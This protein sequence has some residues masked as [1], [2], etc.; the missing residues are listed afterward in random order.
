MASLSEPWQRICCHDSIETTNSGTGGSQMSAQK[1]T[2][3]PR[4]GE[5]A[6]KP[7]LVSKHCDRRASPSSG[8]NQFARP[9]L[10]GPDNPML[11]SL[12]FRCFMGDAT[13]ERAEVPPIVSVW[14][15]RTREVADRVDRASSEAPCPSG[16]RKKTRNH[17]EKVT[18]QPPEESSQ[19]IEPTCLEETKQLGVIVTWGRCR[20]HGFANPAT[21]T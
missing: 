6:L 11:Q 18:R 14:P 9:S 12:C 7:H 20:R 21:P 1:S 17:F 10:A 15:A 5:A 19:V 8:H 13:K 16:L 4:D 3:K 2:R